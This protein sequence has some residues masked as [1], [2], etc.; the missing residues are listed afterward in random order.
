[1]RRL[2]RLA[3]ASLISGHTSGVVQWPLADISS[4]ST[5]DGLD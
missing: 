2:R 4:L 5:E 1:L 3:G